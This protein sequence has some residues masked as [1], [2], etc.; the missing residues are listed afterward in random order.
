MITYDPLWKTLEEKEVSQYR[1]IAGGISRSTL[2]RLKHNK[3]VSTETLDKLCRILQCKVSD[4]IE[5]CDQEKNEQEMISTPA[6]YLIIG[7]NGFSSKFVI[8]IRK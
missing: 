4:V 1:L 7:I 6:F 8:N 5:Y 3:P 2:N